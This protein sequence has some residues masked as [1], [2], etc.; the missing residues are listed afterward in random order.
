MFSKLSLLVAS[1]SAA[2]WNYAT[3]GA[4]WGDVNAGGD[5]ACLL[6]N[7]SPINLVSYNKDDK[8]SFPYK[9]YPS[10]DDMYRKSYSNQ[11]ESALN[12]NGHTTQLDLDPNDGV[13]AFNS[14]M[15]EKLFGTVKEFS[16]V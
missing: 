16:G 8:E 9:T 15:G 14:N 12:F 11:F 2:S 3:N 7:Q 10:T 4:D 6:S 1:S 5:P 13:N